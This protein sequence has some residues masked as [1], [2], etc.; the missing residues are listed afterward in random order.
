MK[1]LLKTLKYLLVLGAVRKYK[2]IQ[3]YDD[4]QSDSDDCKGN[5]KNTMK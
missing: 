5:T 2:R 1:D 3:F 4:G